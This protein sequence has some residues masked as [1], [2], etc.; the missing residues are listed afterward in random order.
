MKKTVIN[1]EMKDRKEIK[2]TD[3]ESRGVINH[4]LLA[5]WENRTTGLVLRRFKGII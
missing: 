3:Y 1:I 4:P 5:R 2:E